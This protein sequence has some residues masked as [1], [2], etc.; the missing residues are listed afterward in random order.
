MKKLSLVLLSISLISCDLITAPPIL[1]SRV[2][3]VY[4]TPI[5]GTT[6]VCPQPIIPTDTTKAW[7]IKVISV[8]R[9]VDR[10]IDMKWEVVTENGVMY[11]TNHK[12]QI[13]DIAFCLG[14]D[15]EIVECD[16]KK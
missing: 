6:V 7:P 15:E 5:D 14:M 4:K 10:N 3:T 13:G 9:N 8:E 16:C 1:I 11:Y 2:D 12:P